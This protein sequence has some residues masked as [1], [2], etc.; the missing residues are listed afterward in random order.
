VVNAKPSTKLQ[1]T[2]HGVF[3]SMQ[4]LVYRD[5]Q[6]AEYWIWSV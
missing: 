4:E 5:T 1:L 3:R 6:R 2:R